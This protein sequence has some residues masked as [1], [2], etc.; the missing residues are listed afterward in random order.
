M[1]ERTRPHSASGVREVHNVTVLQVGAE[2]QISLHLKLPGDLPLED[3]HDLA[4][5][6]ERLDPRGGPGSGARADAH[7]EPLAEA[8][9]SSEIE[10]DRAAIERLVLAET[11]R[12]PRELRFLT[13][14]DGVVA[15]LTLTVDGTT[16]LADAHAQ[17]SHVEGRIR[18]EQPE[19]GEIIVHTEP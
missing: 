2:L 16:P 6:V 4:E 13:S 1:I 14:P 9:E 18:R 19:I 11:G 15:H 8:A 17:A 7:L 3:A 5:R 10:R 12:P